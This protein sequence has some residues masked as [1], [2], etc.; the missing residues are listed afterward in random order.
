MNGQVEISNKE[1]K[2][3]LEKVVNPNQK[4]WSARLDEALWAYRTSF[5]TPLGMSPF[6]LVYG[7]PCHLPVELEHN[8]FWAIKKLYMDL[9]SAGNNHLLELNQMDKFRTQAYENAKIYK[10]MPN[11]GMTSQLSGPFEVVQVYPHGAV[12]V[13]DKQNGSLSKS[14]TND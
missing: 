7:K 14:M 8:E 13:N 3:I 10:E 11:D 9:K 5:K 2:Q 4:D 6:Q 1:I 12:D